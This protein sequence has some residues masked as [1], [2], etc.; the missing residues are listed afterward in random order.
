M[1]EFKLNR[2]LTGVVGVL[3]LIAAPT[4]AVAYVGPGA[5]V[6]TTSGIGIAGLLV[7]LLA[8][9]IGLCVLGT[10]AALV[11]GGAHRLRSWGKT[12]RESD[13]PQPHYT[14]P[15]K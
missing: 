2:L 13:A 3:T 4:K 9:G 14:N 15:K 1:K 5:G 7:I 10:V 6:G 8:A 12:R 11:V